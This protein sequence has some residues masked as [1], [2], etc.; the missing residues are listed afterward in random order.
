MSGPRKKAN[1]KK[2]TGM[3]KKILA[4][5]VIIM[6]LPGF[7]MGQ[8]VYKWTDENG[9]THFGDR[10]PTGKQSESV[11]IRT[12]KPSGT[13]SSVNSPQQKV[14]QMDEQEAESAQ[15]EKV[16]AAEEARQKQRAAN[17][18]TAQN[19][20][21]LLRSGSRIK[22]EENGEERYLT[23]EEI[24]EKQEQFEEIAEVSCDDESES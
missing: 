7:A 2:S 19:N 10:Q 23:P 13:S 4:L 17:C 9:V 11:S 1:A 21:S 16:S 14:Q 22:V 12:G 24:S 18:K 20:L 5:T 3:N 8:S 6:A 15:R